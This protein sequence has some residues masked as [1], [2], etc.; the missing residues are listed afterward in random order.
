M[1]VFVTCITGIWMTG[2]LARAEEAKLEKGDW[3][4]ARSPGF[5]L[6]DG[7]TVIARANPLAQ[8]RVE[9]VDGERVRIRYHGRE[10]D[11]RAGDVFTVEAAEAYFNARVRENSEAVHGYLMRCAI[12]LYEHRDPEALFRIANW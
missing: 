9:Q 4:I 11:A 5:V 1:G 8:Y 6:R 12:R 7:A 3:V 10:G 2:Q